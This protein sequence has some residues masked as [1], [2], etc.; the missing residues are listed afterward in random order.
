MQITLVK[1]IGII[2]QKEV[3]CLYHKWISTPYFSPL[4]C[5]MTNNWLHYKSIH[6]VSVNQITILIFSQIRN[7]ALNSEILYGG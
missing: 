7:R 1:K 6:Y 5:Y 3:F 4:H 2:G